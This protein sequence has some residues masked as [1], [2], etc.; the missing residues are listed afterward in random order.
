MA[1]VCGQLAVKDHLKQF[2][3]ENPLHIAW[4]NAVLD[5]LNSLDPKALLPGSELD[6]MWRCA[7]L[8]TPPEPDFHVKS[9]INE[10]KTLVKALNLSQPDAVTCQSACIGMAVGDKSIHAI[11]QKLVST[12]MAAGSP[13]AMG[14]VIRSY[15]VKYKFDGDASLNNVFEWLKA[16]ELLITH[17][18]FTGSGHVICL[19]GLMIPS[20]KSRYLVNVKDPW[21]EFDAPSW[22][23]N[24]SSKFYDG[25]YSELCIYAACVAGTSVGSASAVYQR[26][27]VDRSQRGMWV[28]RIIP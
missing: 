14:T 6:D 24:K 8:T 12:G 5:R 7:N 9:E 26:G 23:Y 18:W 15:N 1:T 28:H 4:F 16:G 21:S 27:Y 2:D 22:N 19:D 3:K 11:R 13:A 25:F 20:K 17:G 10:W